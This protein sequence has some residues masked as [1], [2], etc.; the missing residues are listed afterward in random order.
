VSLIAPRAFAVEAGRKDSSVDFEK[1]EAEFARAQEH[2]ARLGIADRIGFIGHREGHVSA[3]RRA[4]EFL[5]QHL[6][7]V[8]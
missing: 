1:A 2:Y 5:E 8:G 3:T 4:F 6:G 7:R